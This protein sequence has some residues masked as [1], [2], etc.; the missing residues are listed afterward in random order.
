MKNDRRIRVSKS[1][2]RMGSTVSVNTMLKT[3]NG[4]WIAFI[5]AD[6]IWESE[7]LER[8]IA[9]MKENGYAFSY[10]KFGMGDKPAY[11]AGGP[12]KVMHCDMMKCCW[13]SYFTVMYDAE[14]VGKVTVKDLNE[15]NSYALWL[16]ISKKEDCYL[17][18][19]S[20]AKLLRIRRRFSPLPLKGKFR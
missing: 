8:Q 5:G 3:A 16:T 15:N 14:K 10:T 9:F 13:P 11:I 19:E 17:M 18:P 2:E 1:V 12:D 7:K 6:C 4:R 20:L